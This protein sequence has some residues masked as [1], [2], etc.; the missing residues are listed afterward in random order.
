MNSLVLSFVP[1]NDNKMKLIL[2]LCKVQYVQY[3]GNDLCTSVVTILATEGASF[4]N[5]SF[6]IG[7]NIICCMHW[8]ACLFMLVAALIGFHLNCSVY[9][10]T[11]AGAREAFLQGLPSLSL[12][13]DW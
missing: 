7:C 10:G 11:V 4:T 9:S 12:S 8:R 3:K 13:Y 2:F 5:Y 1:S 6:D